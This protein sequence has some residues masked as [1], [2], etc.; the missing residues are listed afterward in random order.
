MVLIH[1]AGGNHLHWP[2]EIRRLSD[3]PVYALDLPGHGKSSG[4]GLQSVE[5]Y[6]QCILTWMEAVGF[7]QAVF[8]GHSM[9]GAIALTLAM[10]YVEGVLGLGLLSS[11]ARLRVA[12]IILEN[13][14]SPQ[15]L[16][17]ALSAITSLAYSKN[18]GP[19]L[20]E[21][22]SKRMAE[23]R[24][25][26][27]H[28]DFIAC[29]NFDM[30]NSVASIRTPTLILCGQE[31][32]LTPLRYSQYLADQIPGAQLEIIPNAGHMVMLEAPQRVASALEDFLDNISY[33][34][35]YSFQHSNL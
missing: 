3:Y 10:Q 24:P 22:A 7:H 15:S 23:T 16:P 27:L 29:N 6:A 25:S 5:G 4:R 17:T 32:Q 19:R 20:V 26:V 18:A 31:D 13:A 14:A 28:G 8:V 2:P 1:G 11:G 35:G 33:H 30:L 21:Q 34:P 12:P 9:G